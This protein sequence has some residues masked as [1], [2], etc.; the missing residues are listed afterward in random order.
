MIFPGLGIAEL[1]AIESIL[2]APLDGQSRSVLASGGAVVTSTGVLDGPT[3]DVVRLPRRSAGDDPGALVALATLPAVQVAAAPQ[4]LDLPVAFMLPTTATGLGLGRG[5]VGADVLLLPA[6][7]PRS[8]PVDVDRVRGALPVGRQVDAE[9]VA[10]AGLAELRFGYAAVVVATVVVGATV[11]GSGVALWGAESR[12]ELS[13]LTVVGARRGWRLS[14]GAAHGGA[15]A[16]LAFLVGVPPGLVM[17]VLFLHAGDEPD[18]RPHVAWSHEKS[19]APMFDEFGKPALAVVMRAVQHGDTE[20]G[21]ED[22]LREATRYEAVA[23]ALRGLAADPA[24]LADPGMPDGTRIPA[25]L[26]WVIER[27]RALRR[28]SP[29]RTSFTP[30]ARSA[31]SRAPDLRRRLDLPFVTV[32]VLVIA[33]IE[34]GGPA[35]AVLGDRLP[36]AASVRSTLAAIPDP[37]DDGL[38][39]VA[40][41]VVRHSALP[42]G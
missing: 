25:P 16:A 4:Y 22:L 38:R 18:P 30:A 28:P 31:L 29:R 15:I 5:T 1:S 2:G 10:A 21:C 37:P 41:R 39:V 23:T 40:H 6:P 24:A 36:E 17:G 7:G 26:R 42:P 19:E 27:A 8:V 13:R 12:S 34:E 32:G 33:L 11:V 3:L 9:I 35:A 14:A 20:V